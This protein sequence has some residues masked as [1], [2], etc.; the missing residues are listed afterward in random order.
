MFG[1]RK[2]QRIVSAVIVA[3][4]VLAMVIGLI[5]PSLSL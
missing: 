1:N 4:L 5:I 2:F 3:L